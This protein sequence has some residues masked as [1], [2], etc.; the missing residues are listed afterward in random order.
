M[1]PEIGLA[2]LNHLLSGED[3]A[4]SHLMPFSGQTFRIEVGS[5]ALR[6]AITP[7]GLFRKQENADIAPAVTLSLP[8]EVPLRL[9][10]GLDDRSSVLAAAHISGSADLADGLGFVFRNLRW[11]VE[12]D[13]ASLIGDMAAHRLARAGRQFADWPGR[14]AW[15]L[16]RNLAEYLTE[17]RPAI[18]RQADVTEFCSET[19][20]LQEWVSSL[21][22][23]VTALE[24]S[25]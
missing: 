1:L 24:R 5:V 9:L 2:G 6:L 21:E 16:A 14:L 20:Q 3:W 8:A 17:E 15:N 22:K 12:S 23:R 10:A 11:D 18:A 25:K 13:L 7:E 4:R 19:K